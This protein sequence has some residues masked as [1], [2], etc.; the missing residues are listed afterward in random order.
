[1]IKE[2]NWPAISGGPGLSVNYLKN[3]LSGAF[4]NYKLHFYN[5]CRKGVIWK[6]F[7]GYSWR[8]ALSIFG[9]SS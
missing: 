1:M 3:S 6:K 7:N 8:R 9:R 4:V 2:L 5:Q